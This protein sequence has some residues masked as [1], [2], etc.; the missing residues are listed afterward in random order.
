M[1]DNVELK[2]CCENCK[3]FYGC[4]IPSHYMCNDTML[5]DYS[6][7]WYAQECIKNDYSSFIPKQ[8]L[9]TKGDILDIVCLIIFI[10]ALLIFSFLI[11]K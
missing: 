4:W 10:V 11:I 1:K 3:G 6:K 9:Q 5:E 8:K 2:R 7:S